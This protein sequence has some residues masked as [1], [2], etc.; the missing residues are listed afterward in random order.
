MQKNLEKQKYIRDGRA[1]IPRKENTSRVMSANKAKNTKPELKLRKSLWHRGY[2]GYRL[3]PQKV[4]GRP[5]IVFRKNN[6]AIFVNGC[7]WHRCK[8][9][10]PSFPKS[11][12][13]FW[14]EKFRK[15]KE[16]D[17]R[18]IL[19]LEAEEWRTI[20]VWECEIKNDLNNTLKKIEMFF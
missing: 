19:E 4:P 6:L 11:N 9:C 20:T 1:P 15:N 18:K 7:Y 8:M 3:H 2:R 13:E 12:Q 16:R 17:T 5:D 14:K 10:N